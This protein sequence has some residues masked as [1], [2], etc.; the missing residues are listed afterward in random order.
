MFLFLKQ[1][2][3]ILFK[4]LFGWGTDK[5]TEEKKSPLVVLDSLDQN[6]AMKLSAVGWEIDIYVSLWPSPYFLQNCNKKKDK[7]EN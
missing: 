2:Y 1:L 4:F 3:E 5:L 6:K 7:K